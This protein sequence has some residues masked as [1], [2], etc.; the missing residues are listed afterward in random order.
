[1]PTQQT[2]P[3][4][5]AVIEEGG[6]E[7]DLFWH[8]HKSKI[9]LAL[10]AVVCV[11]VGL[12]AWHVSSTLTT[13]AAEAGL[14]NARD[15]SAFEAVVKKYPRSMSAA[16]ALLRI[17]ADLRAVGKLDES[18]A[19]FNRFIKAFPSHPLV[20][21]ALLGIGQ[22]QDVSGKS[23]EAQTTYQQVVARYPKSYAAAFACYSEAEILLREFRKDEAARV[24]NS[25]LVQFPGSQSAGL[26]NA[27]LAR[28][29]AKSVAE[30]VVPQ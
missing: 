27:W 10:V 5:D 1:M 15:I 26:A 23:K 6:V 29:G 12:F 3:A 7:W 19:A 14:A 30:T 21:G 4:E 22:N 16:D 28:I 13:Q 24:L 8:L 25:L 18:T 17:A 2:P 9:L 11:V 20:G